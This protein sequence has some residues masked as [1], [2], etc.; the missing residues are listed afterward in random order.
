VTAFT[1]DIFCCWTT[2]VCSFFQAD[3]MYTYKHRRYVY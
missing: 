1:V 2:C 3:A